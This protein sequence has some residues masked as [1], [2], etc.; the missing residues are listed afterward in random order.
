MVFFGG[1]IDDFSKASSSCGK[2]PAAL[3]ISNP[4]RH[5]SNP[6]LSSLH[7]SIPNATLEL[8]HSR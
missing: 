6:Q 2:S 7:V 5:A 1:M 8:H 3:I 4:C